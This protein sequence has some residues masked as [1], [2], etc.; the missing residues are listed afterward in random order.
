MIWLVL[1]R[2]ERNVIAGDK[3]KS[4]AM[5]GTHFDLESNFKKT[6]TNYLPGH[7]A[8]KC[9]ALFLQWWLSPEGRQRWA[10]L[11]RCD[12]S[13]RIGKLK[14]FICFEILLC[15]STRALTYLV[16]PLTCPSV[17]LAKC[18]LYEVFVHM[19]VSIKKNFVTP[20][21][22]GLWNKNI[23]LHFCHEMI[24]RHYYKWT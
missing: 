6:E 4:G 19:E 9:L 21:S 15:C 11:K 7:A 3:E 18:V 23:L 14:E 22:V 10:N 12:I 16:I 20:R 24:M 2:L 1:I 13:L 17:L 5:T 8:G